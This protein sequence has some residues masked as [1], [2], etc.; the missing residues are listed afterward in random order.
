MK[1]IKKNIKENINLMNIMEI[2]IPI[3]AK[4]E[5]LKI[6]E[7]K[8]PTKNSLKTICEK[9]VMPKNIYSLDCKKF[10]LKKDDI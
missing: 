5:Y 4:C 3:C 10:K 9:D 8:T 2:K 1:K 7:V 6:I